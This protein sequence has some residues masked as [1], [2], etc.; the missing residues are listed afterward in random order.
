M[1]RLMLSSIDTQ[2]PLP[3][4][5]PTCVALEQSRALAHQR[6]PSSAAYGTQPT[7][8]YEQ[9]R[10]G[11]GSAAFSMH[12]HLHQ[13]RR[14]RS[15]VAVVLAHAG[16][17]CWTSFGKLSGCSQP[18][19]EHERVGIAGRSHHQARRCAVSTVAE[20]RAV[21]CPCL[22]QLTI[23]LYGVLLQGGGAPTQVPAAGRQGAVA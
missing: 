9:C 17:A 3:G 7:R 4:R 15:R 2:R 6:L 16:N 10:A 14:H 18:E 22:Q 5:D 19:L 20:P 12:A 23:T 21:A 11:S 13:N 8:T 1:C